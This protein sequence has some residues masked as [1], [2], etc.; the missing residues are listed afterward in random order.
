MK[1]A[2]LHLQHCVAHQL[3]HYSCCEDRE[4]Q[5][6]EMPTY[7]SG[8]QNKQTVYLVKVLTP[9]VQPA[10]VV[11]QAALKHAAPPLSSAYFELLNSCM[12]DHLH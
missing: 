6:C 4:T 11:T 9:Y 7:E 1:D 8:G 10:G 3:I 12:T 2:A 5:S